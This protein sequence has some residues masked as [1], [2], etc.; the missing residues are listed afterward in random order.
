MHEIKRY[1]VEALN[2]VGQSVGQSLDGLWVYFSDHEAEVGRLRAEVD[3]GEN[4]L[5]AAMNLL[6]ESDAEKA[7][8]EA[9]A[10]AARQVAAWFT[11]GNNVPV[12]GI[13]QMTV[14][15]NSIMADVHVLNEALA[16]MGASA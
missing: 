7:E 8:L 12:S 4:N 9:V 6:A 3:V 11:S 13:H 15:N 16:A 14:S 10:N 1:D 2:N 5:A